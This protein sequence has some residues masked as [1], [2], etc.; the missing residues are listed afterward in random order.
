MVAP[1]SGKLARNACRTCGPEVHHGDLVG[2][3]SEHLQRKVQLWCLPSGAN[4]NARWTFASTPLN[5]HF[6]V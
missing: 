6:P 4:P 1:N 3:L 2:W 5:R